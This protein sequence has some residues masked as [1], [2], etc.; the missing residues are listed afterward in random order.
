MAGPV[1]LI[2]SGAYVAAEIASEFGLIPP[3]FLPIGNRR[4]YRWQVEALRKRLPKARLFMTLPADFELETGDAEAL[5]E[6]GLQVIRSPADLRLG[7]AIAYAVLS[8]GSIQESLL[9]LHG[10]TLLLDYPYEESDAVSG[11]HTDAYYAWAG[12]SRERSGA[13]KIREARDNDQASGAVLTGAF[14]F[15]D[16]PFFLRC[17]AITQNAFIDA[18]ALYSKERKLKVVEEGVWLDFG[19]LHTYFQSR[20]RITSERA[21]NRLETRDD[22]FH[23]SS[24]KRAKLE[25]ERDWFLKLPS[26][27]K[28]YAPTVLK[29]QAQRGHGAYL[30]EYIYTAPLSDLY[31]FGRLPASAWRTIFVA[32]DSFLAAAARHRAP[33]PNV[34]SWKALYGPKTLS[35]LETFAKASDID[36][37]AEWTINGK[38]TPSLRR[39]AETL[40]A[41]I[42][43]PKASDISV[44]HGDFCFSNILFDF[45]AQRIKLIDPRGVDA[46]DEPTLFGDRRY[47]TAKLFHSVVGGYDHILAGF[48]ETSRPRTYSLS[49]SLPESPQLLQVQRIFRERTFADRSLGDLKA[50]QIAVLLFL[51]MLPLHADD[52]ARQQALLANGLR[53]YTLLEGARG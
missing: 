47:E 21:F 20:R 24:L 2:T 1:I 23:K 28:V 41:E 45:R 51:S 48:Y 14:A 49:L 39:I 18:I 29:T 12:F 53:L 11:G 22:F 6:L 42:G 30:I 52:A 8:T 3:S 44:V 37:D 19:H 17:L 16:T 13:L 7:A 15:A 10:D 46:N 36:L 32:C 35:R 38:R 9:I 50:H 27:L 5:K 43:A 34:A 40:A 25:A 4:L 33:E 26:E 31:V